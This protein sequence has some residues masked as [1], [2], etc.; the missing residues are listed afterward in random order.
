MYLRVYPCNTSRWIE[1]EEKLIGGASA[2]TPRSVIPISSVTDSTTK[3]DLWHTSGKPRNLLLRER[4]LNAREHTERQKQASETDTC[5]IFCVA[6]QRTEPRRPAH[7][8]EEHM[9]LDFVKPTPPTDD[10]RWKVVQATMRRNGNRHDALIETLHTVQE[11]FGFLDDDSLRYVAA[12]LRVPLSR[13]YGVA[14]FYHFFRMK[15]A[16]HT[17]RFAPARRATSRAATR[18]STRSSRPTA[19]SPAKR[20]PTARSPCSRRAASACVVWRPPWSTMAMSQA[21]RMPA[22]GANTEVGGA[23]TPEE[24]LQLATEE[25]EKQAAF[26]HNIRVCVAAGCLS[27]GSDRMDRLQRKLKCC[28]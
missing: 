28:A 18:S 6:G 15:P 17:A 3:S 10:K 25:R 4:R 5:A 23:M 20:P 1:F 11:S 21:N 8:E 16:K 19:S 22:A 7:L 26:K 12:A 13:A 24:L 27:T 2:G 9:P 14:T